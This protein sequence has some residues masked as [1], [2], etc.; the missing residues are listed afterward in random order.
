[1]QQLSGVVCVILKTLHL[2]FLYQNIFTNSIRYDKNWNMNLVCY[3]NNSS[4]SYSYAMVQIPADDDD[5]D[6]DE[7]MYFNVA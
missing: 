5:D 4:V 1:M 2:P 7:R 3:Q 6:D